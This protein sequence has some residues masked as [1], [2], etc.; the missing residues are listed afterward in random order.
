MNTSPSLTRRRAKKPKTYH[1]RGRALALQVLYEIDLTGHDWRTSLEAH[2]E[3]D[4][5]EEH[6]EA[7]ERVERFAKAA[8]E[9]VMASKQRIDDL[10]RKHAPMWPLEQLSA[11]DRNVLR[12]ALHELLP[13]S[14]VPPKVVINEA[15]ELAKE[16]GGAA[17]GRFVNGVLGTALQELAEAR[18]NTSTD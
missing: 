4:D 8:I 14:A 11:V 15:V 17:S 7:S 13:G 9:G 1:H 18:T 12:L 6:G 2:A 16:Y 10:I 3:G 5:V